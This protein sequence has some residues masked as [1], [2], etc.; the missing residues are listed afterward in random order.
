[1]LVIP[2]SEK[3]IP[4]KIKNFR[5]DAGDYHRYSSGMMNTAAPEEH[6]RG[7]SATKKPLTSLSRSA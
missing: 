3:G 6:P 5:N 2:F 1:M 7:G 4:M